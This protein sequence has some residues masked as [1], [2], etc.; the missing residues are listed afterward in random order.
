MYESDAFYTKLPVPYHPTEN[1]SS[2]VEYRHIINSAATDYNKLI[3]AGGVLYSI[4]ANKVPK[5]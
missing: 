2:V 4:S 1:Y 3:A 5:T